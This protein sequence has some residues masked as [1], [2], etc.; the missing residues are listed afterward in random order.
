MSALDS[1]P[2]LFASSYEVAR[3]RCS[4]RLSR[5]WLRRILLHNL[6]KARAEVETRLGNSISRCVQATAWTRSGALLKCTLRASRRLRCNRAAAC[7]RWRHDLG[8]V[9]PGLEVEEYA[10]QLAAGLGVPDFVYR[11]A[12]TRKGS[13]DREIS[14][15]LLVAGERG[16]ILQ[17]KS[18]APDV[19]ATDSRERASS[20]IAKS[21]AAAVRQAE[22]S[23]RSLMAESGLRFVSMRGYERA[24]PRG[25]DWPAVVL[26]DHPNAPPIELPDEPNVLYISTRD[27]MNL[28][29]RLRSTAAVIEYANRALA[30]GLRPPLG[31]EH[32]RYIRLAE[33]DA[34]YAWRPGSL[35][36]IPL[37]RLTEEE[38][39]AV[40]VFDE[41]V[42]K[43]ADPSNRPWTEDNYLQVVELLDSQPVLLRAT[44]GAK[45][46]DTFLKVRADGMT[47]GFAVRWTG[48][49]VIASSSTT[50]SSRAITCPSSTSITWP[51]SPHTAASATFRRSKLELSR[52]REHSRSAYGTTNAA[53]EDMD[54]LST[55]VPLRQWTLEP[56]VRS[57]SST[58]STTPEKLE[59]ACAT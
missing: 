56:G 20:W 18:R 50:T 37:E 43:V 46:I 55:R 53:D 33:A 9:E 16:L 36:I 52:G 57:R 54:L 21:A 34:K 4:I 59:S 41:L 40:A 11:P 6:L 23:R 19:A 14:D 47:R 49:W 15:G 51:P 27:W 10:R 35:P 3:V 32:Q 13:G 8:V 42:E 39:L 38:L 26:I 22:G 1:S 24:L 44:I 28:H 12:A 31:Q 17:V 2:C 58:A 25:D 7:D 45:M 48:R 29:D 5:T 30:S